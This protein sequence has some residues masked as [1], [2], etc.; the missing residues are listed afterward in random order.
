MELLI[1]PITL[2]NL[3]LCIVIV[4]IS[5][6]GYVKIRS[7]TLLFIG[8]AFFLFGVV[9]HAATLLGLKTALEPE[10]GVVRTLG[11]IAVCIGLFLFIR[12]VMLRMKT[13]D[14]LRTARKGLERR[15]E[16][17]TE[18]I[19][20]ANELL[21]E[22]EERFQLAINAT[23]DGLLEWNIQTNQEFFS[24]R[25]C[26]IIGYSSDDPELPHTYNSWAER[27]H[28]EDY[29]RVIS[30]L[31]NHLEKGT[32]YDVDYRHRHKSGEYRWQ[33]S[34]GLAVFDESGKPV[35]MVGCISDIT[36][37]KL[38][39][40]ALRV[41]LAKYKTLFDT[42]PLGITVSD[43]EGKILEGNLMAGRLLGLS[44][45]EHSRR[46][47]DGEVWRIV[48]PDG[49][50]M[51][52]E[53]YASVRALKENR[54]VENQEMGIVKSGGEITWI[55]VTAAP[56]PLEGH[57]VVITYFDITERKR[58]EE[59]LEKSVQLL[60]D[61]G[62]MA[63]VG[64]WELDLLTK[65]VLWTDEVG[66]IH[67]V[68]PGYKPKLEEALNFYAPESRPAVE[69]AVKKAA[70]TG[71]PYD[72]ESLFIPS[73][74]KDQ[75]WVRSLGKAV[76]SDG[77]IVKLAGTF[78]NIDKYK[79]SEEALRQSE[80]RYRTLVESVDEA[81]ILQEK[82][83]EILTWNRA[84]EQ[85]FGVTASEVLG[86]TAT[87]RKWKT[88][89]EDGTEFSDSEHPSMH[90]LATGEACKN[91]V[92]G[93]TGA[94]GSFSWVNINTTPLF[95]E[96]DAKPY[97]VVISLLDIT[98]RKRAEERIRWLASF[99]ELNPNP[100]IEMDAQGTITFANAATRKTLRDLGLPENPK[101]FV[102]EDKDEILR[103]LREGTELQI[104][105]EI[106]LNNKTFAEN[107]SLNHELHVVRIYTRDITERKQIEEALRQSE[108]KFRLISESSPDHIIIQDRDLR[109][110]WVLNPQLGLR[111]EDIIGKTDYDFLSKEDADQLAPV[112]RQVIETG[113]K[114][115]YET[116][117]VSRQGETEYFEGVYLP[118]YDKEGR[119]D[120]LM[121]YF[122]NITER[123]VAEKA[124]QESEKKLSN[125]LNDVPDV[126]WS[127][128]WPDL[129]VYYISHSAEQ[130]YGRPVQEFT[131]KPSLWGEVTHPD[132]KH[133]TDKALEQLRKE[134]SAVRECRIVR[135]D[136]SIVWIH[137][138]SHLIFDEHGTPIRVDGITSDITERKQAEDA[139]RETNEYLHKLID[140]ASAPII[141]WDPA[142]RITRFN[143]AFGY[144][145]GRTEQE[146][147]GQKID[148]LF[149][150]ESR[151]ASLALI[152][153]TLEGERWESA[154]IPILAA[155]G[156]IHT[157]L[158]NSA[159]IL[160]ED[161][162]LVSTI[163]Q[164]VDITQSE[165]AEE[166]LRE[167]ESFNRGLVENLPE[168]VVVY[169]PDGKI[170]YVNPAAVRGLGYDA[171]KVV[172]TSI[173]SYVAEECREDAVSRMGKRREGG[174]VSPYETDLLTRDGR[175]R[176][177]I[178]KGTP[179][180]FQNNPAYLILF[181]DIT[182]RKR[183]EEA[184]RQREHDFTTLVENNMDMIVRFDTGLRHIYCN[185]AVEDQFGVPVRQFLGKTSMEMTPHHKQAQFID[186][187]LRRVLETG[188]A[189][190]VEQQVPTPSGLKHFLTRIIPERDSDGSIV[191][192]LAI[193]RDIT[194]SK[195]AEEAL[196][197]SE[198]RYHNVIEDQIEFICRFAPN[199]TLTFV[200][201][202]YCRYFGLNK[203]RCI[204]SRHSVVLP[205]DDA[206]QMKKHL[207]ELT[208]ENPVG[209]IEHRITMP[210]GEVRWHRWSDR[211]LFDK[212]GHVIEYQSVGKDITERKQAEFQR[213]AL[214]RELE[215][216]NAE[217]ERF[218]YTVSH[219]LK[220]PLITIR[221]FLG[222]LEKDALNADTVS[223]KKD[224]NRI[225]S[226]TNTMEDLLRDLLAL[227]RI[228]RI[229]SP[230]A[231]VAFT[232]IAEDAVELL[233]GV[234]QKRKVTVEIAPDMPVVNVD[235]DR[236]R[237]AVMNLCENA[238]KF[239]GGQP[240]P[241]IQIG[242]RDDQGEPVFFVQ[243]NGIGI[244][245][246]YHTKIFNL[247]E[248]LD[249]NTEGS[250]TGLAIVQRIIEVHGGRIWVESEG[251]GKGSTFCFTLPGPAGK[252]RT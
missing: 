218:T 60:K 105:R 50:P 11:Y 223:L 155:E 115:K 151:E 221:G 158:W 184:L 242:V 139:L 224:I 120:G 55:S 30:A 212:D 161:A 251:E 235:R 4:I 6:T 144:L 132:D 77:K 16:E 47:I 133:L 28:P 2:I 65:E 244:D 220:S 169:G 32:K 190:D 96:G 23:K 108:E 174:E 94:S 211:A 238:I 217:L 118:K 136:G 66:R 39:E 156:T 233:D 232:T 98:G 248:Q 69:A 152:K 53:E 134:G 228:G 153:K 237:E 81:I 227:S 207:D 245:P 12:D 36:E 189:Q 92:M 192:L 111:S 14:E 140:Y 193:T 250:G 35:K 59:A 131:E 79:R 215:E 5:I 181:V 86:H 176:S 137:D 42:F 214:I 27:I 44:Q 225:K 206:R 246:Q 82:T 172:G 149:P 231:M 182:E 51:P 7:A 177:V 241:M 31:N 175:R 71:E 1:D 185:P 85:I 187:S 127:L 247:F 15:V 239:M 8:A 45:E 63:Q 209:F 13:M 113:K 147:L 20:R 178:V 142:F 90:T 117:L 41:A 29:D 101:A 72:L 48:R 57:G 18:E 21:R 22:S 163:A 138:K 197:D 116:S 61:T 159:N 37:R 68:G 34:V 89:R 10:M 188:E 49:T 93:I 125:I 43:S 171:E 102:P 109:Y 210:S 9:S 249:A 70:E 165:R 164:G 208:P 143:E 205:V 129:N 87:S 194:V 83:G 229:V 183:M 25:W 203:D 121:G 78:Q 106:V 198:E 213:E 73:G 222:H 157:L 24:P 124:L 130:V 230:P 236:V 195:K 17:R 166:A 150:K 54:L 199:G 160:A 119:I 148:I 201:D 162:K 154:R 95:R 52:A 40:D 62:E 104:Y 99:P 64:G 180:Q 202:A 170:L 114:R 179:I 167:S 76:F 26:E 126:V 103:L 84:A 191:S 38:A 56:L 100:V 216:K 46:E 146:V 97:A 200:N 168:Y 123:K 80:V 234:I 112:K 219:D 122:R 196:R 173:L 67:G 226:A 128:S 88:I 107:I 252:E 186:M 243:D 204:G 91:I 74:S 135:S 3:I 240:K 145:A 33:K 141:V 19:K 58:V 75:I 110:I